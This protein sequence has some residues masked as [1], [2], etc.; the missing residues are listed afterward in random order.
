MRTLFVLASTL[1]GTLLMAQGPSFS[2]RQHTS[3]V[4]GVAPGQ[5]ARLNV[6]YSTV[7]APLLLITCAATLTI[8]DEQHNVLKT[9]SFPQLVPGKV[10]S[11]SVNGDTD[12]PTQS[13]TEIYGLSISSGC[14]FVSNLEIIDNA[15]QKTV[16]TVGSQE[17]YPFAPAAATARIGLPE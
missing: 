12:L 14:T 7:P 8:F 11:I 4:V 9:L 13:R 3:G 5:T 10:L 15:T 16:V 1:G 2:N 6:L 17:T